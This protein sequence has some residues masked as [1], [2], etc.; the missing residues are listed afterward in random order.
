MSASALS[1][2]LEVP[3]QPGETLKMAVDELSQKSGCQFL[4]SE[5][6]VPGTSVYVVHTSDHPFRPEY[7]VQS[8]I[9]GFRVPS[10]FPDASPEDA[11]FIAPAT[12]KLQQPDAS[13]NSIDINRA[14]VVAGYVNGSALGE[15]S[16]LVFSWHLW[17]RRPWN[18]RINTLVDHYTHSIRRFEMPEH[19]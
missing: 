14:G 10:N 3:V 16:V 2:T 13:R 9:L 17:D 7:T 6:P 4:I 1:R 12:V 15:I 11:F 5:E 8:G 18:R 19:D